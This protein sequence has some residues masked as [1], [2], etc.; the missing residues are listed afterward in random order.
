MQNIQKHAN[1]FFKQFG[2]SG[3]CMMKSAQQFHGD[4]QRAW[5]ACKCVDPATVKYS[6]KEVLQLVDKIKF[7]KYAGIDE[8][9]E[10]LAA[11]PKAEESNSGW[12]A[13]AALAT[14]NAA[15]LGYKK[16]N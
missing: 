14:A 13:F 11:Q 15:Y 10:E 3:D 16:M 4:L 5:S 7:D 9:A 8:A 1:P 12:V 6:P 2:C